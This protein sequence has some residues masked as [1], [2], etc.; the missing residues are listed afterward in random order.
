VRTSLYLD[1]V[2]RFEQSKTLIS[3]ATI[4]QRNLMRGFTECLFRQAWRN[5]YNYAV[6][7]G[8]VT[9]FLFNLCKANENK[10]LYLLRK[11]Q[12]SRAD[13]AQIYYNTGVSG[14]FAFLALAFF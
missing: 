4:Y 1:Q 5:R 10:N 12:P 14:A 9:I 6:K 11:A 3:E 2:R 13:I 7:G 8:L